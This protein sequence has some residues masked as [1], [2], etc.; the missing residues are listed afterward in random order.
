MTTHREPVTIGALLPADVDRCA[1][2]DA[3]LFTGDQPWSAAVFERELASKDSHFVGAR[4]AGTLIGYAGIARLGF[5]S[6][7]RM[8][9]YEVRNIGVDPAHQGRGIGRQLLD[10]LL[11]FAEGGVVYLEVRCDN[12]AAIGLYRS[13]GFEQAGLRPGYY[14]GV[15][16]ITMRR[17]PRTCAEQSP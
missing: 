11:K 7:T 4:T 2:L 17:E 16:A 5:T 10:E 15:D 6:F 3:L 13:V 9:F 12:E 1:Q 8:F 14:N